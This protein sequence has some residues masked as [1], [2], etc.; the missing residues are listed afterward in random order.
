MGTRYSVRRRWLQ[1]NGRKI[2]FT[3]H[4]NPGENIN[5]PV[6]NQNVRGAVRMAKS[7]SK[8]AKWSQANF[9]L[10]FEYLAPMQYFNEYQT[11]HIRGWG[12]FL[13]PKPFGKDTFGKLCSTSRYRLSCRVLGMRQIGRERHWGL[14]PSSQRGNMLRNTLHCRHSFIFC[15]QVFCSWP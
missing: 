13:I 12:L 11:E 9:F 10:I 8:A 2:F 4:T 3:S 1:K 15:C 6:K 7:I 5:S 14:R